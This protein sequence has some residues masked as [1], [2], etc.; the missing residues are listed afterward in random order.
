MVPRRE[1]DGR[2]PVNGKERCRLRE[3]KEGWVLAID[4]VELVLPVR[5]GAGPYVAPAHRDPDL[6]IVLPTDH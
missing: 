1:R 3:E 5:D 2:A 4:R 6:Q